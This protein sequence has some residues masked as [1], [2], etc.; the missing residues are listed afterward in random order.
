VPGKLARCPGLFLTGFMGSGKSTVGRLIADE[1]GWEFV[2]L[3]AVIEEQQGI[4]ISQVFG[5]QG[6]AE[7]R[8]LEHEALREQTRA[9]ER[10]GPRVVA[11]GG[12]AYA[13]ERNRTLLEPMITVV[14][15]DVPVDTLLARVANETHRPLAK[16]TVRFASLYEVRQ[17]S[18]ARADFRVDG[19]AEAAT[20]AARVLELPLW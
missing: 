11:L 12:G 1:L 7:F 8:R 4:P 6:E 14:W 5:E 16:D 13:Q 20:V 19:D 15:L 3:D 9:A 10:G 2:D 18:Y 17:S